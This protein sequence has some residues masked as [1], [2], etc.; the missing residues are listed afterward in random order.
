MNSNTRFSIVACIALTCL[1]HSSTNLDAQELPKVR[2]VHSESQQGITVQ[3]EKVTVTRIHN[4][5]AWLNAVREESKTGKDAIELLR[6]HLPAR[7]VTFF[8]SV[9]GETKSL[10][11][12]KF[13]FTDEG[14]TVTSVSRFFSPPKWQARIPELTVDTN[15]KGIETQF[16]LSGKTPISDIF[17]AKI[18]VQVTKVDGK[19]LT[20]VFKN[21][22]L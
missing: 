15:A 16:L 21:V 6:Q 4:A 18:E 5:P 11:P 22:E 17:P 1:F 10:G 3:L 9:E 2:I 8:V 12:T 7:V 13:N 20:F 14:K 19:Q